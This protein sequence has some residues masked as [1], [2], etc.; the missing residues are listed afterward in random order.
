MRHTNARYF[1]KKKSI[2]SFQIRKKEYL[3]KKKFISNIM[4][5]SKL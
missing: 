5:I 3:K 4:K 1:S 2:K